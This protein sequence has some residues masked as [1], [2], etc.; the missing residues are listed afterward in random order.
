MKRLYCSLRGGLGNQLFQVA[1]GLALAEQYGA[2]LVVDDGWYRGR[3]LT[4]EW[5]RSFCLPWFQLPVRLPTAR[6]RVFLACMDAAL[7][8]Q[9]RLKW[10]L[11][12]IH[13]EGLPL[14]S[15]RLA[16]APVVVV[17]GNWQVHGLMAP[18]KPRLQQQLRPRQGL[19]SAAH[20]VRAAEIASDPGSV[21]VHVRR[22]DY[23]SH[24]RTAAAH[25]VCSLAYYAEALAVVRQRLS[26]PRIYLFSDDLVW[27][28]QHLPLEGLRVTAVDS[29]QHEAP[30]LADLADFDLMRQCRHAVMA[31]SS[32]SWWAAFLLQQ[33]E[34]LV[35]AP[36]QWF[37]WG[38]PPELYG[39][40]WLLL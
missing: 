32:Y 9:K 31:N 2:V 24:A 28:Q 13:F 5:P 34:S 20:Q 4:S 10:R 27:A 3:R 19:L 21:M 16:K 15:K 18:L 30:E 14:S 39:P 8:L 25:G 17:Q 40:D 35:I 33:P 36:R 26:E 7:K 29:R 12:P 11:L 38:S 37:S 6:Q 22:G 23:V 1:H